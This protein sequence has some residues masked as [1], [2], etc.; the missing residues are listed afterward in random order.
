MVRFFEN[1]PLKSYNTFGVNATARFFF[2]FTEAEDLDTFVHDNEHWKAMPLLVLGGGSNI[3]FRKDF[4]G[5]ILH[6][7]IPGIAQVN[8]SRQNVWIEVGAGEIWDD[9]VKYCVDR[10]LG[11]I[12]N[13]SLIPGLVGA[14]PVQNIGAYGQEA[15]DVIEMVKG[16]DLK[17]GMVREFP[18]QSC[19]F[20]YRNSLFKTELKNQFIITSVVFKLEKFP[21][22]ILNYGQVEEMVHEMGEVNIHNVRKAIIKIRESKLPDV[23]VLGNAGS[24][25]K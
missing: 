2:E 22:F 15:G 13:L 17:S 9:F 12:E 18:A 8:E 11:G 24:F 19:N 16:Y 23:K 7:N 1:F 20:N 21:E 3:L 5:L 14:A 10:N 6:P 4:Q 25:F